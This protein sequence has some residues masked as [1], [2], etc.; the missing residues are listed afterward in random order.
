MK[1]FCRYIY[2]FSLWH[3]IETDVTIQKHTDFTEPHRSQNSQ[4]QVNFITSLSLHRGYIRAFFI[5]IYLWLIKI[6]NFH[7]SGRFLLTSV[8]YEALSFLHID[9]TSKISDPVTEKGLNYFWNIEY[10]FCI[11]SKNIL[12]WFK[13]TQGVNMV[14][15]TFMVSHT[16]YQENTIS[17]WFLKS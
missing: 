16:S 1:G 11:S 14:F 4:V 10:D 3:T 17:Q 8:N 13:L 12:K 7:H 5:S 9:Y 6:Q 15:V 2:Q